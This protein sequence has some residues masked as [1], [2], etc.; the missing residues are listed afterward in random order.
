MFKNSIRAFALAA[1]S[2]LLSSAAS[3]QSNPYEKGPDPTT[4]ALERNGTFATRT[5]NVSR[6]SVVGFGGARVW[7]PTATGTYGAIAVSPGFTAPG[8][9]MYFWGERLSSHGFVVIV[10]DTLTVL[11]QPEQRATQLRAALDHV[12]AQSRSR[13]SPLYNKVD[14]TRLAVAGHSMGGGGTLVAAVANGSLKAAIPMAPWN[15]AS[16]L[17]FSRIRVPTLILACQLDAIAPTAIHA[18]AFYASLPS[19]TPKAY[20]EMRGEDHLCVM[21]NGGHYATL[22][23]LGIAWAKRWIDED[24]RYDSWIDGAGWNALSSVE[25]S[26]KRRGGF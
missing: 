24:R 20:A 2:L 6:L 11:D 16:V 14:P 15:L 4:S 13:T 1:A 26:D 8:S 19:G 3:A 18:S 17:S 12:V 5:T 7:Y 22:G 21:N 25:V 23:K 10:I 9:T